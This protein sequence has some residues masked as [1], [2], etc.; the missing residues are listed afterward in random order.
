M[1]LFCTYSQPPSSPNSGL[2]LWSMGKTRKKEIARASSTRAHV[3]NSLATSDVE[4]VNPDDHGRFLLVAKVDDDS[5]S[6]R[7]ATILPSHQR[8]AESNRIPFSP[9]RVVR[10]A[11]VP[12]RAEVRPLPPS[13]VEAIR[14]VLG[15]HDAPR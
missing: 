1:Y 11:R 13:E 4:L 3:M 7:R 6:D 9:Q 10:K 12:R 14:S 5:L 2:T 15:P 8:A